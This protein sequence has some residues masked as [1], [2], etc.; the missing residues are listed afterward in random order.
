MQCNKCGFNNYEGATTC[1]NCHA[2]LLKQKK[3]KNKSQNSN[4]HNITTPQ[5]NNDYMS[6]KQVL[7][8]PNIKI[9]KKKFDWKPIFATLFILV[10]LGITV[11]CAIVYIESNKKAQENQAML[12]EI[13]LV[14][15]EIV[16]DPS[17]LDKSTEQTDISIPKD[18]FV[19]S[20][21]I[22]NENNIENNTNSNIV[23]ENNLIEIEKLKNELFNGEGYEIQKISA[24]VDMTIPK[25]NSQI[26]SSVYNRS[27]ISL[28]NGTTISAHVV[29]VSDKNIL[30][31]IYNDNVVNY[32][33]IWSFPNKKDKIST[34]S[35]NGWFSYYINGYNQ[36]KDMYTRIFF[37]T[38][39]L[40]KTNNDGTI[41]RVTEVNEFGYE[42]NMIDKYIVLEVSYPSVD[43]TKATK[44]IKLLSLEY[45]NNYFTQN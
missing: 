40:S 6:Q 18:V 11:F 10:L 41:G 29:N 24:L 13:P 45:N 5:L 38:G 21:P 2:N 19:S 44:L 17:E 16:K 37:I 4:N 15:E 8:D 33:E 26:N 32:Q 1:C 35:L 20:I 42:I 3:K 36:E 27:G 23:K 39:E 31:S 12:D 28:W 25:E 30:T 7:Y 22:P 14:Q 9:P 34:M 43:A